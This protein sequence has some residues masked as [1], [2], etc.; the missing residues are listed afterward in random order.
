[1]L[2]EKKVLLE[3][4]ANAAKNNND[5]DVSVLLESFGV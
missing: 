3:K 2:N 5:S 1:M 4:I